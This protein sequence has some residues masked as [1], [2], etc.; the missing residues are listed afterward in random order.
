MASSKSEW[1]PTALTAKIHKEDDQ[2]VARCLE[3]DIA[4][5]GDTPEEAFEN[6]KDASDVYVITLEETGQI[7]RVFAERGIKVGITSAQLEAAQEGLRGYSTK[8]HTP[9]DEQAALGVQ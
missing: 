1:R 9:G 8:V 5:C 6:L 7:E 2:Y 4:S 3:L